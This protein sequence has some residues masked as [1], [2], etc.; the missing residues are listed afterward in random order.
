MS[1]LLKILAVRK[2]ELETGIVVS[3]TLN[4][5]NVKV[6]SRTITAATATPENLVI[7]SRVV[8]GQSSGKYYIIGK[9]KINNQNIKEVMVN[10]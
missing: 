3:K 9:E 7:G 10:G 1:G 2:N 6:G 5:V 4:G 8:L